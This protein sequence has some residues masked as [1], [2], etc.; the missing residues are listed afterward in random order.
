MA[1]DLAQPPAPCSAPPSRPDWPF[2]Q[3]L[4]SSVK[5]PSTGEV[6]RFCPTPLL[7]PSPRMAGFDGQG[8]SFRP[9]EMR[10]HDATRFQGLRHCP[11][12]CLVLTWHPA[13][14]CLL[15]RE[16][17]RENTGDQGGG[18]G[19]GAAGAACLGERLAPP[20]MCELALRARPAETLWSRLLP[21]A[22]PGLWV[23]QQHR[24]SPFLSVHVKLIS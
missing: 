18:A 16:R 23:L 19:R 24:W 10:R 14:N 15:L 11:S 4:S 22:G 5:T 1:P 3:K 2:L 8:W 17:G 13:P 6:V 12:F 7:K 9:L 20:Q 21:P